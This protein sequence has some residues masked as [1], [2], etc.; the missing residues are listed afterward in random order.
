MKI[1]IEGFDP[2]GRHCGPG[3][4][5]P[6]GHFSVHVAV[7]GREGQSDLLGLVPGDAAQARI[8][9]LADLEQAL[10]AELDAAIG[11]PPAPP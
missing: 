9:V 11:S 7:Q 1:R 5:F 3:P 6:D 8:P 2:P 10:R 4:D